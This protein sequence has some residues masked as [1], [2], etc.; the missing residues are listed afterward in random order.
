MSLARG[1]GEEV[2]THT[3]KNTHTRTQGGREGGR[4][5]RPHRG[6]G[7]DRDGDRD[8][9]GGEA[10]VAGSEKGGRVPG[11]PLENFEYTHTH[12]EEG[13]NRELAESNHKNRRKEA[14]MET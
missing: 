2:H 11:A 12:A 6:R 10:V 7:R 13:M 14:K 8:K 1:G 5:K 9:A 3:H 4:G